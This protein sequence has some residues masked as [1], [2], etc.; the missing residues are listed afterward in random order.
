MRQA[1]SIEEIKDRLLAQ[2]DTVLDRYAPPAPGSFRKGGRYFT[3]NPGRADRRVGSF[4][5]T[6]SGPDAGRWID[7]ATHPRGGDVLDLI[8][9]SLSLS[10]VDTIREARA[11]L[12]LDIESPELRRAREAAAVKAR[13]RREADALAE[14]A[15]VIKRRKAAQALWL[16]AQERIAGTPVDQYL[17]NR[18]ID[19][20]RLGWQP[21]AIRYHP[22]CL[23]FREEEVETVDMESGEITIQ[24]RRLPPLKLPAM[25]TAIVK[26]AEHVG[27]HRT[28]LGIDPA[29][30]HWAKAR[31]PDAKKVLG[32]MMGGSIRL[33]NGIGPRGGRGCPLS[34]CPAGTRVY[35]A[36]GIE[37]ALSALMVRPAVRMLAA[38][39]LANMGEIEL[40]DNVTEVVLMPDGDEGDQARAMFERAVARHAERGRLVRVL[41]PVAGQDFNDRLQGALAAEA[42]GQEGAA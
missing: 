24:T 32:D 8:G 16:S 35:V 18:G 10:P 19:L 40:P 33:G 34:Q 37:T 28:Y 5:V 15:R 23:Y 38:V 41:P 9:L 31:V 20:G 12:G 17:R 1:V 26:G 22:E 13:A 36:E 14:R 21:R 29:T 7:F 4:C 27:T 3:L 11:F 6:L 39:S 42:M 30:G 2:L 25:V